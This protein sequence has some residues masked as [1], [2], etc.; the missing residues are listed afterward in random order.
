MANKKSGG[1]S[2]SKP[3]GNRSSFPTGRPKPMA[4]SA[5]LTGKRRRYGCGGKLKKK[6]A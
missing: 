5:G 2:I 3:K 4:H 6:T 1:G